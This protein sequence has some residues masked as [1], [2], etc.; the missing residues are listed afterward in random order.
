M[1][2]DI[3]VYSGLNLAHPNHISTQSKIKQQYR[4]HVSLRV[5]RECL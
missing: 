2:E 4:S 3:F 5:K 1:F